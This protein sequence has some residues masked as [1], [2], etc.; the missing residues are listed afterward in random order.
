MLDGT[1]NRLLKLRSTALG[2]DCN[3]RF[4]SSLNDDFL[5]PMESGCWANSNFPI[6][7]RRNVVS[8]RSE[9]WSLYIFVWL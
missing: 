5:I 4:T 3:L 9:L 6:R 8:F 1:Y 2:S 7:Q